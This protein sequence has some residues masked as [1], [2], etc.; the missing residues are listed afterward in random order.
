[1]TIYRAY[2]RI[3]FV[4]S[5]FL[6]LSVPARADWV[7]LSGAEN[8]RNIA[9]IYI[10]NDHVRLVLEVYVGDLGTFIDLIPDDM[11]KDGGAG[12]PPV[13]DRLRNFSNETFQFVTGDGRKLLAK[14]K[15]VEPRMRIERPS[16]FA[17]MINPVTGRPVPGPPDDKR[18]LYAEL[19]YPFSGRPETLT[20]IPPLGGRGMAAA[21]IGFIAYHRG[22]PVVDFRFLSEPAHLTLDWDDPWYSSFEAKSLKRW[23]QSGVKSFLYIEPYEVRHEILVRVKDLS[24]WMDLDIRGEEFIEVDE[25]ELLKKR[26]GEFFLGREN[27]TIDGKRLRP[28]LDRTSF[29]KYT[30][31]RTIFLEQPER[32]PLN[33][34]MLGVIITYITEGIPQEVTAGWDLFSDRMQKVPVTAE[35]PAGPF[36]SYLTPDDNIHKWTNFLKK[37]EIP[38]VREVSVADTVPQRK[39]PLG[40]LGCLALLVPVGLQIRK[41]RRSGNPLGVQLGLAAVLIAGSILL[42]PYTKVSVGG[43]VILGGGIKKDTASVI[44]HS[45]L[46]NVYRSFDFREES[47]VYD[48]LALSVSGDLLEEI[49]LQNRRSFEVKQA[50]GARAR[51]KEVEIEDVLVKR[52][53]DRPRALLLTS[54]WTATGTVGH[55]GH[56]HIR[57]NRY[58]ANVTVEPVAGAWKITGLELLEE[59]RIDQYGQPKTGKPKQ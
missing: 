47:D 37:Y 10:E 3:V 56:I 2:I 55:W 50:G 43:P 22:V 46:K 13:T 59:E 51:V 7:N 35:D 42:Y 8:A 11:L 5:L 30:M 27:V 45:L 19:V 20:I 16:P 36:P 31:M 14:L 32:L 1:M 53:D 52:P 21:S 54:K 57:Q 39:I 38:Q 9:E 41:R 15:L 28:I 18:V 33:T 24:A 23:Q 29:I 26:A 12:L 48:R 4:L 40:T 17:G 49:Y 44:L 34:A 6:T 25:L 58:A